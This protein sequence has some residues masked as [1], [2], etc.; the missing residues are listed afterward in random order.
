MDVPPRLVKTHQG[1][2]YVL[3]HRHR[4]PPSRKAAAAWYK[5][6]FDTSMCRA[7]STER[8]MSVFLLREQECPIYS[9]WTHEVSLV[10]PYCKLNT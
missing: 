9:A 10:S 1:K 6:D 5:L 7:A 3:L 4:P 2:M 8:T